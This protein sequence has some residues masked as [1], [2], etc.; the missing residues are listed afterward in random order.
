MIAR[1]TLV[2]L[3]LAPLACGGGG[4]D[5]APDAPIAAIDARRVDAPVPADALVTDAPTCGTPLRGLLAWWA[6]EGDATDWA[7]AN[8]GTL[9]GGALTADG[10]FV[11]D[12]IDDHVQ[13]APSAALDVGTGDVTVAAWVNLDTL[14]SE[15]TIFQKLSGATVLDP[16]YF[17]EFS[18]P[19]SVRF[20]VL[21][22]ELDRNDLS[23]EA[24]LT[25]GTWFHLVGVREGDTNTLYVDGEQ[26]G[27]ATAGTGVD[28]GTGGTTRI[29][30]TA[31]DTAITRHVDGQLDDV[32]VYGR[33]LG[34]VE[35][36]ALHAVG[37]GGLCAP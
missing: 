10:A 28:T 8:P 24:T 11:L 19:S 16:S 21:E 12:G 30:R 18:P 15:Q 35:V 1:A 9:T 22:T 13:V 37:R 5:A 3:C 23:A 26:V 25:A 17:L 14:A 33:A 20:A 36:S 31:H 32:M 34:A 2:T 7:G 6:A 29:G 27:T 4:S